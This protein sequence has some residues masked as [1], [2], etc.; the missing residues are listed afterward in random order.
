MGYSPWDCKESDR[1][2][3]LTLPLKMASALRELPFCSP[4]LEVNIIPPKVYLM[5]YVAGKV[6]LLALL[7][8][9]LSPPPRGASLS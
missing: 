4:T 8:S 7:E 5:F 3:C 1:A 2:E 9:L 6:P